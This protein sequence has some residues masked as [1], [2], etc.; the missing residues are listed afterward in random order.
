[1]FGV[2]HS[3]ISR[4]VAKL[5]ALKVTWFAMFWLLSVAKDTFFW[6]CLEQV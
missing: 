1:M 5:Y 6:R 3:L 4:V 2:I